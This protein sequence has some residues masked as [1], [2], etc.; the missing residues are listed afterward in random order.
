MSAVALLGSDRYGLIWGPVA[1]AVGPLVYFALPRGSG[2]SAKYTSGPQ[3]TSQI[4]A[5]GRYPGTVVMITAT[6]Q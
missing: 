6:T 1:L 3:A 5:R 4:S 2:R